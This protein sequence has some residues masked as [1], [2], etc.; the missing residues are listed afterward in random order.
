MQSVFDISK[1]WHDPNPELKR[2]IV[3][4]LGVLGIES[5]AFLLKDSAIPFPPIIFLGLF[6]ACDISLFLFLG[7]WPIRGDD[8]S[9][10]IKDSV[11]VAVIFALA[12]L[13]FLAF[14]KIAL[15]SSLLKIDDKIFHQSGHI[16]IAFY[17]TSC[18]LSPIAEELIFRGVLYRKMRNELNVWVC[19]GAVSF[20]FALIHLFANKQAIG[21][22]LGS[23]IFCFGYEK[24]K[25]ILTPILLHIIGNLIIFLSPFLCFI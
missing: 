5:F 23:L 17:I 1:H 16:V 25:S 14:W 8:I 2:A 12:G 13:F 20:L 15:G 18:L 7:L 19:I 6:R 11:A 21:P 4:V 24:T 3:L 10:V 22:F 9:E